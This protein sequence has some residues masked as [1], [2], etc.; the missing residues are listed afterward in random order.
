MKI[1]L[2]LLLAA[3]VVFS[4]EATKFQIPTDSSGILIPVIPPP[5]PD[6]VQKL[7]LT[8][9]LPLN[10]VTLS[11]KDT[12]SFET[13]SRRLSLVKDSISASHRA[14]E[15]VKKNTVSFMPELEPKGEFEKQTEYDARKAKWDKELNDRTERD[16]KS[17][18]LRLA[19]LEKARKKI[20]ENQASLYSSVSIKSRPEAA[21]IWI[22]KEEIGATPAEYEHLIPGT[23]KISIRK[24]GYNPWDTTFV[25][26][27]GGGGKHKR[28]DVSGEKGK[29]KREKERGLA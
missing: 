7:G 3:Y 24:E 18:S 9:N 19:E 16:T 14:M 15:S 13:Y 26:H 4:Q 1:I 25:V 8:G 27:G 12:A 20:E 22:G 28:R 5:K 29:L 21:S 6:T 11:A 2:P 17:L 23:V 10:L